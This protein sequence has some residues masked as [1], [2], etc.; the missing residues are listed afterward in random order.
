MELGE[1]HPKFKEHL[2]A[3]LGAVLEKRDE[4]LAAYL[5]GSAAEAEPV[6]NDI[7]ILILLSES[8]TNSIHFLLSELDVRIAEHLGLSTD[9]IDLIPFDL[10]LVEPNVLYEALRTGILLKCSDEEAL[11]DAIEDLS[12]YFLE[13]E[14]MLYRQKILMREMFS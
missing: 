6:V 4:V 14:G 2:V 11:T 8:D 13:N 1:V 10:R 7:D 9:V 12:H 5:F 3:Q